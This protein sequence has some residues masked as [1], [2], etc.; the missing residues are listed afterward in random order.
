MDY[1]VGIDVSVEQS[2]VCVIDEKGEIVLETTVDT[3]PDVIADALGPHSFRRRLQRQ[4]LLKQTLCDHGESKAWR[5]CKARRSLYRIA[6]RAR[7]RHRVGFR[8]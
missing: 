1:Y 2:S 5:L 7:R 3:H 4:A 8:L 6:H